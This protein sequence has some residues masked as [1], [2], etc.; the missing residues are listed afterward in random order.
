LL[1]ALFAANSL[2]TQSEPL[3]VMVEL[4]VG[5]AAALC[6]YA[7]WVRPKIIFE[8]SLL[9]VVNPL[10]SV[11]ILYSD[12]LELNTKWALRIFHKG[13]ATT[14]WVA[15]AGG[16]RRWIANETLKSY[17]SAIP[18]SGDKTKESEASSSSLNSLSGQ[19]AYTIKEFMKRRH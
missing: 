12:I 16:K 8:A 15:P 9:I 2:M 6:A 10:T 3:V 18:L 4:V 14:A 7:L 19:A 17:G 5:L 11:T 13:G 1:A